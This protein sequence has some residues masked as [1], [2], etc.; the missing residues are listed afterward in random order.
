M[1][2]LA[3]LYD[4][5]Q[6]VLSALD[7]DEV[8]DQ[9]LTI[10]RDYFQLEFNTILLFDRTTNELFIRSHEGWTSDKQPRWSIE[11]GITGAAARLRRPIYAPDVKKDPRYIEWIPSTR[12]ELAIPLLV[13]EEVVGVLDCQS[14]RENFF[15]KEMIDLLT[16]FSTQ[17]SIALQNAQLHQLEQRRSQQLEAINAIARETTSLLDLPTLLRKVCS[18]VMNYFP[19]A[20][21]GLFLLEDDNLVL[22]AQEGKHTPIMKEADVLPKGSGLCARAIATQGPVLENDV[23]VASDYIR[24]WD[25][26]RSELS[27][28]LM[29]RG[30]SIGVIALGS[31]HIGAFETGDVQSLQSVADICGTAI[32][33]AH[34]FEKVQ[35]LAYRDGLTGIFNRRYFEMRILEELARAERYHQELT[36]AMIDL[37]GFKNLND[38][39]GHLLGD[40]VL[41]QLSSIFTQQ[42][43]KTDLIFRFG[44]DEFALLLVQTSAENAAPVAE[45]LRHFISN[46]YFPGVPRPVGISVGLASFPNHGRTRDELVKAAD[47]ALYTAKQAGRNRVQVATATAT[48]PH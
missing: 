28:P 23:N 26:T 24:G 31:D 46:F 32:Q 47:A 16:I 2:K 37:D 48:T 1:Q 34:Y 30:E 44:G 8:L 3:I 9:I 27:L 14:S 21:V 6:A 42:L 7:L 45:K 41:R 4:A 19:V 22:R 29:A 39:F 20:N 5:S 10:V 35:Q 17:A 18:L 40:E 12:S 11:H 43:R 33:N 25:D 38:E 13:R 36:V 15:D